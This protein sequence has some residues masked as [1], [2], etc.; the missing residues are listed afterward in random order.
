MP[1]EEHTRA[2]KYLW[3]VRIFK[4]RS[5][6]A[7]ACGKGR[8]SI[9]GITVKASHAV[10]AGDILEVRKPPVNY[11][12]KVKGFPNSR[13]SPKLVNEFIED[14]TSP[15]ELRKLELQESFFVKRERGSG[16]PTKKDRRTLD[17]LRSDI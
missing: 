10:K 7:E 15:E 1:G 11:S 4:T 12:Y 14:T 16:R 6:A 9:N 5:L 17:N 2:D 8:I 13:T 3:C